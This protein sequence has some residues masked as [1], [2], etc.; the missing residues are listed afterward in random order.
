MWD[1]L[2]H[3]ILINYHWGKDGFH[4]DM[5]YN[6]LESIFTLLERKKPKAIL[7]IGTNIG[8]SAALF[9]SYVKEHGG[10]F[11]TI[12]PFI[13]H[14]ERIPI[15]HNNMKELD[16]NGYYEQIVG[17][18]DDLFLKFKEE[19]REFDFIFIDGLHFYYQVTRDILNYQQLL[20]PSGI[21]CGH[22]CEVKADENGIVKLEGIHFSNPIGVKD[23]V[24]LLAIKKQ[25][26]I[27]NGTINITDISDWRDRDTLGFTFNPDFVVGIH[28]GVVMSVAQNLKK[29]KIIGDRIFW[30]VKS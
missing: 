30:W 22:D 1:K 27:T 19:K 26:P 14:P 5:T 7:E 29:A 12:D 4:G 18:S 23:Y 8:S 3:K 28:L 6:D 25:I 24:D 13:R 20:L 16:L 10:K 15:F 21:L 9:A 2:I 17:T 11:T